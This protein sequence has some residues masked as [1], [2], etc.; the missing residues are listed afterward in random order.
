M[1]SGED[2]IKSQIPGFDLLRL[3]D[4]RWL[5]IGFYRPEHDAS[6][7]YADLILSA[8]YQQGAMMYFIKILFREV[9]QLKL[10]ELGGG[11]YQLGELAIERVS[12]RGMEGINYFVI[13]HLDAISCYCRD[14]QFIALSELLADGSETILWS[15]DAATKVQVS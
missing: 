8:S 7:P 11:V 10:P 6:S 1:F 15:S 13:D 14:V 5:W 9:R 4:V 2:V 3:G 12:D